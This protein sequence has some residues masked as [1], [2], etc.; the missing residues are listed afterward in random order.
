PQPQPLDVYMKYLIDTMNQPK[1]L[2]FISLPF[3]NNSSKLIPSRMES[4]IF[5]TVSILFGRDLSSLIL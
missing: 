2:S 1:T 3:F 4:S 5:F